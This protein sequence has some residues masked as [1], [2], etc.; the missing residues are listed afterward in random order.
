MAKNVTTLTDI[1]QAYGVGNPDALFNALH[2]DIRLYEYSGDQPWSG[3]WVG[4]KG[5]QDFIAAVRAHM[6]HTA[7]VCEG[8]IGEGDTVVSWGYVETASVKTGQG[9]KTPWMHRIV[10]KDGKI[11]EIH[12][13]YDSLSLVGNMG[14]LGT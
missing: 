9:A 11:I 13:F 10:F 4:N 7:Y 12:E 3:E 6:A 8:A 2:D 5:V 1:Y 14:L